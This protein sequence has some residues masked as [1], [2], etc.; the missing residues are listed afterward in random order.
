MSETQQSEAQ[1]LAELIK[2][3]PR[4]ETVLAGHV[5]LHREANGALALES[6][7]VE[8][9]LVRA[10]YRSEDVPEAHR[11][12]EILKPTK[13]EAQLNRHIDVG[14]A[15]SVRWAGEEVGPF[16]N[17]QKALVLLTTWPIRG[18]R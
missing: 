12:L 8:G 18:T 7:V 9:D 2:R 4:V 14:G 11:V 15:E 6:V 13:I 16:R 3:D 17:T 10:E 1:K 5:T